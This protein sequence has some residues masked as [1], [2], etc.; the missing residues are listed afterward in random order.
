MFLNTIHF[1]Q[2]LN[3]TSIWQEFWVL[4]LFFKPKAG[5][6]SRWTDYNFWFL[7][8]SIQL[9]KCR[10]FT[11][12]MPT[13]AVGPIGEWSY[14]LVSG[15]LTHFKTPTY[16]PVTDQY[17]LWVKM[18]HCMRS[19]IP[20]FSWVFGVWQTFRYV[21]WI[22]RFLLCHILNVLWIVRVFFANEIENGFMLENFMLR[23][24]CWKQMRITPH[25]PF[26]I[27]TNIYLNTYSEKTRRLSQN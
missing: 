2:D 25:Q 27:D 26:Q 4:L 10:G 21:N 20:H 15:V 8:N 19:C 23:K 16:T 1:I 17:S 14:I 3:V 24:Y 11:G 7:I 5:L 22:V 18:L 13:L 6:P 12:K 9:S